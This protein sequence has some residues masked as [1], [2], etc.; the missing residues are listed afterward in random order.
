MTENTPTPPLQINA[1]Y[2]KDLSFEA[3]SLPWIL[4][5]MK[6]APAISVDIDVKVNKTDKKGIYTV[7]LTIKAKAKKT[8][9]EKNIFICE[10]TYG[11]VATLADSVTEIEKMLLVNVPTLIFPYA[12]AII[13]NMTR[14]GGFSPLQINPIDFSALYH[15]KKETSSPA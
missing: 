11:A 2:V 1:Q 12:R 10:L 9:D 5:E 6:S 7:D 4:A 13:A 8:E 15:H 14:E 3:P